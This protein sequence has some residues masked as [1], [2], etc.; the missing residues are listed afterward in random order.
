LIQLF[1]LIIFSTY[2]IGVMISRPPATT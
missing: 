1:F 2:S